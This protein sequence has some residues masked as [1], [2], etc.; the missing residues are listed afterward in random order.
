M[1]RNFRIK[2]HVFIV[3]EANFIHKNKALMRVCTHTIIS[4]F[5]YYN[6]SIVKWFDK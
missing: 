4:V 3:W 2:G 5:S 6:G 1:K